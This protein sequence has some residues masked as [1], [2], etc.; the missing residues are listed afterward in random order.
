MLEAC[1]NPGDDWHDDVENALHKLDDEVASTKPPKDKTD[2]D[3][4]IFKP[5]KEVFE[6]DGSGVLCYTRPSLFE[7]WGLTVEYEISAM[8]EPHSVE[9]VRN[10]VK[11]AK[12][13][14]KK[15]RCAGFRHTWR[16]RLSYSL[17]VGRINGFPVIYMARP[18]T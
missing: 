17:P 9:G 13:K 18:E 2:A 7:N 6:K 16:W 10:V 15:V 1:F 5:S 11:W 8:F 3:K 14:G 4:L 12:K